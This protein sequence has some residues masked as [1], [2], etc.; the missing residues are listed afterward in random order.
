MLREARL[1]NVV[2]FG[3]PWVVALDGGYTVSTP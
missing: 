2:S 1:E 3:T